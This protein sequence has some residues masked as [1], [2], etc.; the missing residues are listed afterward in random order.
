[1]TFG[2]SDDPGDIGKGLISPNDLLNI[3]S[4][5]VYAAADTTFLN[6]VFGTGT[7]LIGKYQETEARAAI[8]FVGFTSISSTAIIDSAVLTL[9]TNYQ[10]KDANG[11]IGFTVH[12]MTKS[13]SQDSLTW[14]STLSTSLYDPNPVAAFLKNLTSS[15]TAI[16]IHVDSL[17]RKYVLAGTNA[18][19]GIILLPNL[20]SST[21]VAGSKNI[22]GVETRPK[23]KI[24]YRNTAPDTTLTLTL[25]SSQRTFVANAPH[26]FSPGTMF[27][28]AGVAYR[29]RIQFDSLA[30]PKKASITEAI[31]EFSIDGPQSITNQ[32]TRDSLIVHLL[33]KNTYPFDSL[34]L[35][36]LCIP[37]LNGAQKVYRAT[38]TPLVQQWVTREPNYGLVVRAY[39]EFF[40][41]DRFA[42][43]G[44]SAPAGLRPKLIITYTVFK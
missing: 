34:A 28:Q 15:D 21:I 24:Y 43:F 11:T 12:E 40:N 16:N 31:I 17:V 29:A 41:L 10:F 37:A 23:L 38:I 5:T 20:I 22:T 2:C 39:G 1:M 32:H 27:T 8:Q 7:T 14:D 3:D 18:P 33:R 30:I 35:G 19:N 42:L 9:I 6:R 4:L 13:W 36:T 44:A 25:L 26:P